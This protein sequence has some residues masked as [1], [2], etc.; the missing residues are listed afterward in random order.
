MLCDI[1]DTIYHTDT[2]SPSWH[3]TDICHPHW[4]QLSHWHH[5]PPRL[6]FHTET[7]CHSH[8]ICHT[9]TP[10]AV[11]SFHTDSIC[12]TDICHTELLP[13]CISHIEY[14]PHHLHQPQWP[15]LPHYLHW[16]SN[17]I[18]TLMPSVTLTSSAT[19]MPL[20][21]ELQTKKLKSH[22]MRTQSFKVLPL[23]PGVGQYIAMHAT[24]TARDFFVANFYPFS[25][26]PAFFSKPFFLC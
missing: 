4:F 12:H 21:G 10:A 23:K 9:H 5:L 17:I 6:T 13:H 11:I 8:N 20:L 2:M 14:L 18:S 15:H 24:L 7:A 16:H 22:L 19:L 25:P 3:V 26:S 1:Y